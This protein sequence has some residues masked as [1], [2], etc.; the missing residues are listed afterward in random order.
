MDKICN[1]WIIDIR[2][3]NNNIPNVIDDIT[4]ESMQWG[5]SNYSAELQE[6]LIESLFV[7]EWWYIIAVSDDWHIPF[8]WSE[9]LQLGKIPWW[10]HEDAALEQIL[11]DAFVKLAP[12]RHI[13]K[14]IHKID[15]TLWRNICNDVLGF[16]KTIIHNT[17]DEILNDR[18]SIVA[19]P[20]PR[21]ISALKELSQRSEAR[22]F[23]AHWLGIEDKIVKDFIKKS[24]GVRDGEY[25][26]IIDEKEK[27]SKK[28]KWSTYDAL[29]NW[30]EET[31]KEAAIREYE[32]ET[33]YKI[34]KKHLTQI[35]VLFETKV[36]EE[37]TKYLKKRV[38]F[39]YNKNLWEQ[40]KISHSESEKEQKLKLITNKT[41]RELYEM[42]YDGLKFKLGE[43]TLRERLRSIHKKRTAKLSSAIVTYLIMSRYNTI[44]QKHK[45]D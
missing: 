26:D 5:W 30:S 39:S 20:A 35:C 23:I 8:Q 27:K 11:A 19:K 42:M 13:L 9:Y 41:S 43:E 16:D 37:W 10:K 34:D 28:R 6:V 7:V 17:P 2:R 29:L 18:V 31:I 38:I 1:L 44:Y 45:N 33:G 40:W 32:E 14:K 4:L 24:K 15:N 36:T 22:H 21:N 25:Q 12:F 3:W